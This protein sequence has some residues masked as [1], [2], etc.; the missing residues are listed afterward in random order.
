MALIA[1]ARGRAVGV[2]VEQ[3]RA[4]P[5]ADS[6]AARFFSAGEQAALAAVPAAEKLAAFF[7][8]WTRKEAFIKP[9]APVCLFRWMS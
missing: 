8:I 2:D 5:D 6:I 4:M 3:V 1:V 9:P 7:N